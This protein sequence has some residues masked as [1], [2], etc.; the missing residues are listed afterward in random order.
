MRHAS[1]RWCVD[2]A[3]DDGWFGA[4]L[5]AKLQWD[6][7]C[8]GCALLAEYELLIDN[9]A[10]ERNVELSSL[11]ATGTLLLTDS[12]SY[13]YSY[14]Y[15]VNSNGTIVRK[16]PT[17]NTIV[18][19][20]VVDATRYAARDGHY[21][22]RVR[23]FDLDGRGSYEK[24]D[25]GDRFRF[26]V[27]AR[28]ADGDIHI[29]QVAVGWDGR[30]GNLTVSVGRF[31]VLGTVFVRNLTTR[32]AAGDDSGSDERIQWFATHAKDAAIP[33]FDSSGVLSWSDDDDCPLQE[34]KVT[35]TGDVVVDL[36]VDCSPAL[37]SSYS[38]SFDNSSSSGE[39]SYATSYSFEGGDDGIN[40]G[41][42][43]LSNL[44]VL[45]TTLVQGLSMTAVWDDDTLAMECTHAGSGSVEI[46]SFDLAMNL[47]WHGD[48]QIAFTSTGDVEA[49]ISFRN[50][51]ATGGGRRILAAAV[52]DGGALVRFEGAFEYG[53]DFSYSYEMSV[54]HLDV[55][56]LEVLEWT[57][58]DRLKAAVQSGSS[59]FE[60]EC[61]H[62]ALA[63]SYSYGSPLVPAF[64]ANAS[65]FWDD[66]IDAAVAVEVEGL[67]DATLHVLRAAGE[68]HAFIPSGT[69]SWLDD[70]IA[71][72]VRASIDWSG[73]LAA[74]SDWA[75]EEFTLSVLADFDAADDT[76]ASYSFSY[77]DDKANTSYSFSYDDANAS[78]SFS[79]DNDAAKGTEAS[80]SF[81]F[82]TSYAHSLD[83]SYTYQYP[84]AA[85]LTLSDARVDAEVIR[86][87]SGDGLACVGVELS[88]Y[89]GGD[90]SSVF[91]DGGA[92]SAGHLYVQD[93]VDVSA[94]A[95]VTS[96]DGVLIL[97]ADSGIACPSF[98][99]SYGTQ[100]DGTALLTSAQTPDSSFTIAAQYPNNI[101]RVN[102][103]DDGFVAST[104]VWLSG[105]WPGQVVVSGALVV[106][107]SGGDECGLLTGGVATYSYSYSSKAEEASWNDSLVYV[108]ADGCLQ[109]LD[110]ED[111]SSIV[112]RKDHSTLLQERGW[113]NVADWVVGKLPRSIRNWVRDIRCPA[114]ICKPT[115]TPR[116]T[117]SPSPA[118]TGTPAACTFMV[119]FTVDT[120]DADPSLAGCCVDSDTQ[121]ASWMR[122]G[123][124]SCNLRRA[125]ARIATESETTGN[126]TIC[127]LPA[128]GTTFM[129]Y[130]PLN[131][132]N[133]VRITLTSYFRGLLATVDGSSAGGGL[134]VL[135]ADATLTL[136]SLRLTR[137]GSPTSGAVV[138]SPAGGTLAV[139]DSEFHKI[140]SGEDGGAVYMG[141]SSKLWVEQCSFIECAARARGGAVA[142]I[143]SQ[144][145]NASVVDT[146]F[147]SC[148]AREAGGALFIGTADGNASV[149]LSGVTARGNLAPIG[150]AMFAGERTTVTVTGSV[151]EAN[152]A[153]ISTRYL[154]WWLS[155]N[156]NLTSA[157]RNLTPSCVGGAIHADTGAALVAEDSR[158]VRNQANCSL[159]RTCEEAG[160]L[161]GGSFY[162]Q[163][164][165]DIYPQGV[166]VRVY[167]DTQGDD[168]YLCTDC[169]SFSGIKDMHSCPVGLQP[170][171]PRSRDHWARLANYIENIEGRLA[172]DFVRLVP[173]YFPEYDNDGCGTC[174]G[175]YN[176][177]YCN[178][179]DGFPIN[180]DSCSD[181]VAADGGRWWISD[182]ITE[183]PSGCNGDNDADCFIRVTHVPSAFEIAEGASVYFEDACS[184]SGSSYVCS[185]NLDFDSVGAVDE[186]QICDAFEVVLILDTS[187]TMANNDRHV[188][189][190]TRPAVLSILCSAD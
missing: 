14:S 72:S 62:S 36:H 52:V 24:N 42:L 85:T 119:D 91:A 4:T 25:D 71:E 165:Y 83:A 87:P 39:S 79:Y 185:S 175:T 54:V 27:S 132:P 102:E 31:E 59:I 157:E 63:A 130:G 45:E 156:G 99:Y 189:L 105:D 69:F 109:S 95:G 190:G 58:V 32:I 15:S 107:T 1:F 131:I 122:G 106:N 176:G 22:G 162:S 114:M 158:F 174:C 8:D 29:D 89:S 159:P 37:D 123:E 168:F 155:L 182:E 5:C 33:S 134:F 135:L 61:T 112:V 40:Q 88:G 51:E 154:P 120:D 53:D 21:Y 145:L 121:N 13:S 166:A 34:L 16:T 28:S 181:A 179:D 6:D 116:P 35:S 139:R 80:Y 124:G 20:T 129:K 100:D 180:S 49:D 103:T 78:Y 98:S 173:V 17:K 186:T 138:R 113:A 172:D 110:N 65:I 141:P 19:S 118:P 164:Y 169:T 43:T 84:W 148:S 50:V 73:D 96:R 67:I 171:I 167:C 152:R 101:V 64:A 184:N 126:G 115:E 161:D 163:G 149:Q 151:F 10:F 150:G 2:L 70:T 9:T 178:G 111:V 97:S 188:S 117:P 144:S 183:Y 66:A 136:E 23:W 140:Y 94:Y 170:W 177:V 77:H 11:N 55:P 30:Q 12:G 60:T 133:G 160:A 76:K 75:F 44:A 82:Q 68:P 7:D 92:Q 187:D 26:D 56:L 137:F 81:S 46:P 41:K 153:A 86:S 48:D 128:L 38:Y 18:A 90:L 74:S 3:I 125:L 104:S 108:T 57:I 93:F 142:I 143:G 147:D 127:L 47:S 146:T